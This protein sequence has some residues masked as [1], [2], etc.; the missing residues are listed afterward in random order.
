MQPGDRQEML[1]AELAERL[2]DVFG[3]RAALAG[4]QRRGD[5]A[6]RAR[7]HGGDPLRHPGAQSQQSFAPTAAFRLGR[8]VLGSSRGG[9][10]MGA[11]IAV[12]DPA[13]PSEIGLAL[14]VVSARQN[15][16]GY[17]VEHRLE[18]DAVARTEPVAVVGDV[19]T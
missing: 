3:D 18:G 15:L 2:L 16:A 6:R 5:A 4:D 12:A 13:D 1:Q 7:Q 11:A 19:Q 14:Q 8:S 17:R 9:Q 10:P